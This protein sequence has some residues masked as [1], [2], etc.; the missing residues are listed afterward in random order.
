MSEKKEEYAVVKANG[1]RTTATYGDRED[2]LDLANRIRAGIPSL[3]D[4]DNKTV[5]TFAQVSLAHNLD[6]FLGEAWLIDTGRGPCL[7]AGI[8]GLRKAARRQSPYQI[9]QRSA[10]GTEREA[11]K[12]P[13]NA[14]AVVTMVFRAD[15]V[16]PDMAYK[17]FEGIGIW[18][19]GE[20]VPATKSGHWVAQ[21]RSE[22][23]A[24]RKAFDLPFAIEAS[25][26]DALP[27]LVPDDID[28]IDG[29]VTALET[30]RTPDGEL[31]NPRTGEP[32]DRTG[33]EPCTA[34][35]AADE[36]FGDWD[37]AVF[38]AGEP[39]DE[40]KLASEDSEPQLMA[41]GD[42]PK[43]ATVQTDR[44]ADAVAW[45]TEKT[46]HYKNE[47]HILTALYKGGY[48]VVHDDNLKEALA[49]LLK[50]LGDE[51]GEE[52]PALFEAA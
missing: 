8:K 24:L 40:D 20:R 37:E 1:I 49:W 4:F 3:K 41:E 10:S 50:R 43:R 16:I 6:P 21:K 25:E 39:P 23:D 26:H 31:V 13:N 34:Q 51:E 7:M 47:W 17:P 15:A 27:G 18:K 33:I 36:L 38:D 11:H 35:E 30:G 46:D 2:V 29:M 32:I 48:L 28:A 22:A 44:W 5:L 19:P 14:E 45:L 42:K 52:Q 9:S 12:V